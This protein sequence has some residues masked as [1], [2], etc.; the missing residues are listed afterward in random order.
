MDHVFV[1]K[2]NS[3]DFSCSN[4]DSMLGNSQTRVHSVCLNYNI[5]L[6][7]LVYFVL[8]SVDKKK[9]NLSKNIIICKVKVMIYF[10]SSSLQNCEL[11]WLH[12]STKCLGMCLSTWLHSRFIGQT[13]FNELAVI[14][15]DTPLPI[16]QHE[17][18]RYSRRTATLKLI[19]WND[20]TIKCE[21]LY[22][23]VGQTDINDFTVWVFYFSYLALHVVWAVVVEIWQ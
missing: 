2:I 15:T 11:L 10:F 22:E 4:V 13:Y 7:Q 6:I 5:S 3:M 16:Y 1:I 12:S 21:T 9:K 17:R 8:H 18:H 19:H 20:K 14:I 23:V